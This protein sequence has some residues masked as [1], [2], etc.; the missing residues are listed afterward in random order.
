MRRSR[1]KGATTPT[2][3]AVVAELIRAENERNASLAEQHLAVAFAGITRSAGV[4]ESREQILQTIATPKN[5]DLVRTLHV[6]HAW[7]DDG[8]GL[9]VVRS[10]VSTE[11]R[12]APGVQ[13][14]AYR[15]VHVLVMEAG[16]WKCVHWQATRLV[17]G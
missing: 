17:P 8:A 9:A 6:D 15:N 14:G 2:P 7:S 4:E 1:K 10:L 13:E 12:M 5:P 16:H 3:A 11:N